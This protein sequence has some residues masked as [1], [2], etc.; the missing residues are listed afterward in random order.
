ML[1]FHPW[2]Q[3]FKGHIEKEFHTTGAVDKYHVLEICEPLRVSK[4]DCDFYRPF[5]TQQ[6]PAS[7][8][9]GTPNYHHYYTGVEI[10]SFS[11][12]LLVLIIQNQIPLHIKQTSQEWGI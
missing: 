2:L 6:R 11:N 7:F 8:E 4:R 1:M 12:R 9:Q 5:Y 3:R 10:L